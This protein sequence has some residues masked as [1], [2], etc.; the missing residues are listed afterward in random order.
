M[1]TLNAEPRLEK[2]NFAAGREIFAEGEAGD[3]AYLVE[4]GSVTIH[5][6]IDGRRVELGIVSPGEIFG[7]MAAIDGGRRMATAVAQQRTVATRIPKAMFDRKLSEADKFVRGIVN[8]FIRSIRGNHRH[9][10]RRPRSVSD[11]LRLMEMLAGNLRAFSD[12]VGDHDAG[13]ELRDRL[14]EFDRVFATVRQAARQC[15]DN[16][17]DLIVDVGDD[18]IP[19]DGRL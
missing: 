13:S 14:D 19:E 12:K 4:S 17:H 10:V 8:F 18:D 1:G 3:C 5:Q 7:E 15:P 6:L 11:Q 9:F 2:R 16:R